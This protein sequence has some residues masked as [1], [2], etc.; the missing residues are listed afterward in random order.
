MEYKTRRCYCY[1]NVNTLLCITSPTRHF[2]SLGNAFKHFTMDSCYPRWYITPLLSENL[3]RLASAISLTLTKLLKN[4]V[5]EWWYDSSASSETLSITIFN[6]C[7]CYGCHKPMTTLDD[8]IHWAWSISCKSRVKNSVNLNSSF[9]AINIH[10]YWHPK[11]RLISNCNIGNFS[12]IRHPYFDPLC[13]SLAP[14]YIITHLTWVSEC[15]RSSCSI[16]AIV[17]CSLIWRPIAHDVHVNGGGV[18]I[19]WQLVPLNLEV[20]SHISIVRL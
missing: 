19:H 6:L 20:N 18:E 9:L 12:S 2:Y 11:V 13:F 17:L 5:L 15:T 14:K 10:T 8:S 16:G 7:S 4:N 3:R 1:A